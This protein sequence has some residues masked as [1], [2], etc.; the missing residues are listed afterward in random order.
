M[1]RKTFRKL[2]FQRKNKQTFYLIL[3]EFRNGILNWEEKYMKN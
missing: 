2:S 3:R 1:F